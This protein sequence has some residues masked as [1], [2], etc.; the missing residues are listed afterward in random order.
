[1]TAQ[2]TDRK[3]P[4]LGH[5]PR[6]RTL[7][8][9]MAAATLLLSGALVMLDASGDA[10]N[11]VAGNGNA[12]RLVV[13]KAKARVDNSAGASG[14]KSVDVERGVF[15]FFNSAGADAIT[16]DHIGLPAF[17]VDNQTVAL[18]ALPTR[19]FAGRIAAVGADGFVYVEVGSEEIPVRAL[20]LTRT[21]AADLR[22][23]QFHFVK[24]DN[25]GAVVAAG[26]GEDACGVLQ[27]APNNTETAIVRYVG[28]TRLICGGVVAAGATVASNGSGRGKAVS[29]AVTDTTAGSG[30]TARPV[31]ASH[32]M[33]RA[34]SAAA[35]DGDAIDAL[36]TPMGALPTTAS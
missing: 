14:D 10:T 28:E 4:E 36:L 5:E 2:T 6:V 13:G 12:A 27:N 7:R 3:V 20:D 1:M 25:T 32:A 8:H 16:A 9:T 17:V 31:L 22:T 30:N 21:A 19:P 23:K 35:A 29:R 24:L 33:G 18:R 34:L 15:G 11:A 26:D